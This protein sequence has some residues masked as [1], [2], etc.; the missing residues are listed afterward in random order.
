MAEA[1]SIN[2]LDPVP[3]L[4]ARTAAELAADFD[5]SRPYCVGR[6]PGRLDV[7]GGIADYMGSLV[8][9]MPLACAAAVISQPRTDRVIQ[10]F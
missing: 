7:M 6:A 1:S 3:R 4:L 2:T 10:V 9:E 5:L 8:C